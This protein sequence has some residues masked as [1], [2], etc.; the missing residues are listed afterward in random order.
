MNEKNNPS[1]ANYRVLIAKFDSLQHEVQEGFKGVHLR[2][3]KANSKLAKH[4]ECIND[5]QKEDIETINKVKVLK[6]HYLII[7]ILI[8]IIS[9][10]GGFIV[11]NMW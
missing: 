5:L 8:S 6:L 1:D 11:S 7:G 3:D 10:L 2:Q 9:G 4:E